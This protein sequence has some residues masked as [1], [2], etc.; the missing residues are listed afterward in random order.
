MGRLTDKVVLITGAAGAVGSAVA[1]AVGEAGGGGVTADLA[2]CAGMDHALDVTSEA[3]WRRTIDDLDRAA[4]RLDGLVNAAG[5]ATPGSVED[6]DFATRRAA[7]WRS[8]AT[9]PF[10][11]AN[12]RSRCSSATAARS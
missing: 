1:D 12:T 11:A 8:T 3:D 7:S 5:I 10:S 4:G 9:A 6:T 2:G